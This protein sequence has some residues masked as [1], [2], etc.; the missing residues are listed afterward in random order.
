MKI[1]KMETSPAGQAIHLDSRAL[2]CCLGY[3]A[4]LEAPCPLCRLIALCR[5]APP[6]R[7]LSYSSCLYITWSVFQFL[8]SAS[9]GYLSLPTACS[10][11]PPRPG[12][13]APLHLP[14]QL[15]LPGVLC[16]YSLYTLPSNSPRE[17]LTALLNHYDLFL[18]L[19]P[20]EAQACTGFAVSLVPTAGPGRSERVSLLIGIDALEVALTG[21]QE[22]VKYL[23]I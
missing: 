23:G 20:Q 1:R 16:S 3:N 10:Q 2:Y 13:C 9:L 8:F 21:P 14:S 19:M 12:P 22:I 18:I 6:L 7:P 5:M 17:Y 4:A 11:F 15:L